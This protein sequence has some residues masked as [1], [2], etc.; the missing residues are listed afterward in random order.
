MCYVLCFKCQVSGVRCQVK[1]CQRP[2]HRSSSLQVPKSL[3]AMCQVS[4]KTLPKSSSLLPQSPHLQVSMSHYISKSRCPHFLISPCP[5][6]SMSRC[7]H[8][9][10]SLCAM[11]YVSSVRC[12]VSSKT[13]PKSP[14][15]EVSKSPC[16]HISMSPHLYVTTSPSPKSPITNL[17]PPR[18]AQDLK[19]T[20]HDHRYTG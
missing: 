20:H 5:H 12:Q 14:S 1:R 3:C 18:S 15:H 7:L 9:P 4:S 8:V 16:L 6:I 2:A 11:C 17:S 10:K 19:L 13:L